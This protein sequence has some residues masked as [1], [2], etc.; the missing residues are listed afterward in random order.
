MSDAEGTTTDFIRARVREDIDAGRFDGPVQT[1]FPPEPNGYLHIG[2]AK[3]INLD[4]GIAEEFGG[5]CKLRFDDTNPAKEDEEF[6]RAIKEDVA[7]LG[8]KW[9]EI[10]FASDYFGQLYDWAEHLI[11]EGKAYVDSQSAEEITASRGTPT[12]PGIDSPYRNRT[13]DENIDLFR[14]M[15]AGEFPNGSH[16]LR[17]RI[18]MAS[19]NLN[20][21]DPVM[22]RILHEHHHRTGDSWCIYP[23]YD[24]A[25]GQSD[26]IEHVTHSLCTLEFENHRPLYNWYIE[27][28]GI[29]P[30]RQIE[31]APLNPSY[32][33][34][35]KRRLRAL[36]EEGHVSGWD[37]PRMPTIAGLRR[38][39]YTPAS[40]REFLRLVGVSK[41]ESL[42]DVG[43]LDFAVRD[44]LN[45]TAQRLMAVLDPVKVV[46]SNYPEHQTEAFRAQNNPGDPAAGDRPVTFSREIY[47]ERSDFTEDP[48]KKYFRL[49]PGR[50]VRLKHAYYV[51]CTGVVR[52]DAGEIVELHCT[53]DPDSRG[54]ETPDGRKVKGTLQWVSVAHAVDVEVR[55]FDR[56]FVREEMNTLPADADFREFLN[57]ESLRVVPAAKA[58]TAVMDLAAGDRFQF[59]R[60]G[61]FCVDAKD[62]VP[63][64]PVINRIT[65]LRDTWAKLQKKG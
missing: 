13:V 3:A 6:V 31:F 5:R 9:E 26:A 15:R 28:L 39:G 53:Y 50:E 29:W 19:P 10:V 2:H 46:I 43:L 32:T 40:I 11:R 41:T 17:A 55:L 4:F 65:G 57:P 27:Q 8:Y 14:R 1:R 38:R 36:V 58:E 52:D 45:A 49:A 21:R 64:R 30:S 7:W 59:L 16:V 18:D 44:E 37:D 54:G 35:S 47:I 61:Y 23:L 33:M 12:E 60:H 24:W 63:G 56:L 42:V 51:T 25:H 20:L 62:S 48:P 22:Y 34:L